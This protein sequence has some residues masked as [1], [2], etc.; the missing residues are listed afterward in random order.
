MQARGTAFLPPNGNEIWKA[1]L[2]GMLMEWPHSGIS[3]VRCAVQRTCVLGIS[4]RGVNTIQS[5]AGKQYLISA[6]VRLK[7]SNDFH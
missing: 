3:S 2:V 7:K 5:I 6:A 1:T 4:K